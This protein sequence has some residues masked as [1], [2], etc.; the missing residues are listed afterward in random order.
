VNTILGGKDLLLDFPFS[1]FIKY[2]SV[3]AVPRDV[4]GREN[5]GI[6]A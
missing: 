5:D 1:L 2:S 6:T 4:P 3:S